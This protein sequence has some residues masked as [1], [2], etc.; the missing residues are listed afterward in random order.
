M[1]PQKTWRAPAALMDRTRARA[2]QSIPLFP[3]IPLPLNHRR[4]PMTLA[5]AV[6]RV[7]AIRRRLLTRPRPRNLPVRNLLLRGRPI[8]DLRDPNLGNPNR[9]GQIRLAI[10]L[11][12]MNPRGTTLGSR[13][14]GNPNRLG[15]PN[16]LEINLRDMNPRDTTLGS[17]NNRG[18]GPIHGRDPSRH[19]DH[20]PARKAPRFAAFFAFVGLALLGGQAAWAA[21]AE[22]LARYSEAGAAFEVADYSKARALFE[23]AL[24]A[25]MEGP[26]I[27][28]NIG[29]AAYLAVRPAARRTRVPRSRAH[30]DDGR[31]GL[32]QPRPRGAATPRRARS[33]PLVRAR[34]R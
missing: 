30:A 12:D 20:Q 7:L 18:T 14:P 25:G 5:R 16:H 21:S 13:N 17:R 22:A 23:Q 4:S 1:L 31:A 29:S 34:L 11:R 33:A 10:N 6:L 24:E 27:H 8:R 2:C 28:Y 15:N 9:L 32:L 19:V 26:A 3:R